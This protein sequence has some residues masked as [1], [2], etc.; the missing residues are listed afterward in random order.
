MHV[1]GIILGGD[2]S[3]IV[4]FRIYCKAQTSVA[5]GIPRLAS[6]NTKEL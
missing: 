2:T 3:T 5:G 6:V 4:E 1:D